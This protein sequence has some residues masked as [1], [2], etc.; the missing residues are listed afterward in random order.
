MTFSKKSE[1]SKTMTDLT[2][3]KCVCN[4]NAVSKQT[5]SIKVC[6][7]QVKTKIGIGQ[8]SVRN[9][10]FTFFCRQTSQKWLWPTDTRWFWRLSRRSRI[11]ERSRRTKCFVRSTLLSRTTKG[12]I[13][14]TRTPKLW[15]I[16]TCYNSWILD[17]TLYSSF[18]VYG[19]G[20]V[21]G[22]TFTTHL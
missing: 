2:V 1:T 18:F 9:V 15:E 22:A 5:Q 21:A 6:R 7:N 14:K 4:I 20:F 16:D 10:D 3:H 17:V 11:R 12:P 13:G 19:D 8:K